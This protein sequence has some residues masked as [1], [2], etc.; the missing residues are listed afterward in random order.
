MVESWVSLDLM[1]WAL[2]LKSLNNKL[3]VLVGLRLLGP[4]TIIENGLTILWLKNLRE[5][6]SH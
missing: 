2:G 1:T 3:G 5:N 4:I 6:D